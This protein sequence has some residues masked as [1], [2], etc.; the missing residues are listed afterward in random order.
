M[1]WAAALVGLVRDEKERKNNRPRHD[2]KWALKKTEIRL[3]LGCA[4]RLSLLVKAREM[5][6]NWA[7]TLASR[8]GLIKITKIKR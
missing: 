1:C 3:G 5:G 8:S 2:Q 4:I 7:L 6:P